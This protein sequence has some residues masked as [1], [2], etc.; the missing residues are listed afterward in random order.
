M[1]TLGNVLLGFLAA[2]ASLA[3]YPGAALWMIDEVNRED[4]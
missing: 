3:G 4:E 1:R 2:V